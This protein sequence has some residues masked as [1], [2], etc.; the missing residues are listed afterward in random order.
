MQVITYFRYWESCDEWRDAAV[1]MRE[2]CDRILLLLRMCDQGPGTRDLPIEARV[3]QL[4]VARN[5]HGAMEDTL[6]DAEMSTLSLVTVGVDILENDTSQPAEGDT[7]SCSQS[8][9]LLLKTKS[10]SSESRPGQAGEGGGRERTHSL[11]A[12][13]GGQGQ[14]SLTPRQCTHSRQDSGKADMYKH[15]MYTFHYFR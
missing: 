9:L 4:V 10:S 12:G 14:A 13:P 5:W 7:A 15:R 2:Y 3:H 8:P 6:E 11:Q 1:G